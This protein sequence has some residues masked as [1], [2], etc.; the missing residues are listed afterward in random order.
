MLIV[1]YAYFIISRQFHLQTWILQMKINQQVHK[2]QSQRK[3]CQGDSPSLVKLLRA[4]SVLTENGRSWLPA[5][6]RNCKGTKR[7]GKE[8]KKYIYI[9]I[10]TKRIFSFLMSHKKLCTL[11]TSI[12]NTK[13][14]RL[15]P[16]I[17]HFQDFLP[18]V[19]PT[20]NMV[21]HQKQTTNKKKKQ[22]QKTP[23]MSHLIL[24]CQIKVINGYCGGLP[25]MWKCG[26]PI[27]FFSLL[28]NL[29]SQLLQT[30]NL[31]PPK[32]TCQQLGKD[33]QEQ[34]QVQSSHNL[35]VH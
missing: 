13:V 20:I 28:Y 19:Q 3:V 25:E 16:L 21:L 9:D 35:V 23:Q 33:S 2:H 12:A 14:C 10:S 32:P 30:L 17:V 27:L 34:R 18:S 8:E 5:F 31:K 29:K 26:L 22:V 24:S 6:P 7:K 4:V 15:L 11:L 1:L